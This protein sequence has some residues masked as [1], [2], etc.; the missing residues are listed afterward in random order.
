M[1]SDKIQAFSSC[2][3]STG[4]GGPGNDTSPSTTVGFVMTFHMVVVE[5][6]ATS[7]VLNEA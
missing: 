4:P 7:L 1:S 3:I 6:F 5:L 2:T